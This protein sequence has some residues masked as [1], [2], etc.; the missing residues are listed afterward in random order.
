MTADQADKKPKI[1][2]ICQYYLPG[3]K[4]GGGLRTIVNTVERLKYR[5][6]FWV[7]TRDHDGDNVQYKDI[8][9]NEWNEV[10][11]SKILYLSHNNIKFSKLRELILE[12][13]PDSIYINSVFSTFSIIVLLLRRF[14]LIPSI[15]IVLAP[16]G[17]LSVSALQIK[18]KKKKLFLKL[19]KGLGLH[20]NLIWKTTSESEKQ[21]SERIKGQGGKVFIAANLPSRMF[22]EAY[23]QELKPIKTKGEMKMIFLSRFMRIKNFNWLVELLPEIKG[24]LIIDIYGPLEDEGYWAETQELLKKLPKNIAVAYKGAIPHEQVVETIFNYHFFVLPTLGENFGH[25]FIE[26]LAA[27]CPLIISDRTPWRGLEKTQIGWDLALEK[28]QRWIEIFNYC[29]DLDNK[30]YSEFSSKARKYACQW[31]SDPKVEE[32]T[33]RVL[34]YSLKTF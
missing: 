27:G 9:I 30:S 26:A 18:K 5:F 22:L 34:E 14:S 3:Y 1:L 16:E 31:L 24:N 10:S 20:K 32:D 23:N 33:L 11:D 4:G 7:I 12:V 13:R 19:A 21:E 29:I 8:K 2:I 15:N 28:S 25:V 17:E 6:D